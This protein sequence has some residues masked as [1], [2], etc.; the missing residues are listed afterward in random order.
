MDVS[1][2][3]SSYA[4]YGLWVCSVP[5]FICWFQHCT[6]CLLTYLCTYLRVGPFGF[7]AGDNKRRPHLAVVCNFL[8]PRD[9]MLTRYTLS[10]CVRHKPVLYQND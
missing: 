3:S 10:S 5:W 6:N 1:L 2:L 8:V 7:Q 4:P 9:A